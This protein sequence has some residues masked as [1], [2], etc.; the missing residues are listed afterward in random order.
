ML[1]HYRWI[2][3]SPAVSLQ[4]TEQHSD[5]CPVGLCGTLHLL[6]CLWGFS[7]SLG[8]NHLNHCLVEVL[9]VNFDH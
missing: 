9:L 5:C 8:R 6:G 2:R 7:I 4:R 1:V 3:F